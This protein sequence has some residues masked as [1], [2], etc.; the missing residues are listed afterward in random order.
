MKK[1]KTQYFTDCVVEI[2]RVQLVC[3][4]APL[5]GDIF[6]LPALMF[7]FC[8]VYHNSEFR[9]THITASFPHILKHLF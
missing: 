5:E 3:S 9:E 8:I 4:T 1:I 7:C 6:H 2:G